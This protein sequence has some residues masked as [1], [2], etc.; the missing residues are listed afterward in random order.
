MESVELKFPVDCIVNARFPVFLKFF[1]TFINNE[2]GLALDSSLQIHCH[3][4]RLL[5]ISVCRMH[6]VQSAN[7]HDV[8]RSLGFI[9][10]A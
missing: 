9:F 6:L 10:M 8:P 2:H 4:S 3:L 5:S 7:T 1:P